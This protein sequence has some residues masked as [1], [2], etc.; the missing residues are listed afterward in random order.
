MKHYRLSNFKNFTIQNLQDKL[1]IDKKIR[2]KNKTFIE[3]FTILL[4][5]ATKEDSNTKKNTNRDFKK[6]NQSL[7]IEKKESIIIKKIKRF[8]YD[9]NNQILNKLLLDKSKSQNIEIQ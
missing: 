7:N 6:A 1:S 3:L 2:T 4:F 8:K 9:K 5:V